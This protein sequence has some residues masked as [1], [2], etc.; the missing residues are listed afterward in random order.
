MLVVPAASEK[1]SCSITTQ[2]LF[3]LGMGVQVVPTGTGVP[4]D[5]VFVEVAGSLVVSNTA[6]ATSVNLTAIDL[7][8]PRS[9]PDGIIMLWLIFVP[10]VKVFV[11]PC[12]IVCGGVL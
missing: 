1:H 11:C 9:E 6:C 5:H 10:S 3:A 2:L 12:A 7:A 8:K 4:P